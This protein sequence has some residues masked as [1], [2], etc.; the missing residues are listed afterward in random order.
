MKKR[1]SLLFFLLTASVVFCQ[2]DLLNQARV[3]INEGKYSASQAILDELPKSD[4]NAETMYLNAKSSK[5]L[6]QNDAIFLYNKLNI[7]FPYH[8]F[9]DEVN[10]D[11]ALI[12]YRQKQYADAIVFFLQVRELKNEDLFKLGYCYFL[13]DSLEQA[14]LYFFRIM[15]SDSK[16]AS[17]S[18]YYYSYILYKRGFYASALEGFK[19]LINDEKFGK[20]VPYYMSQIYF[21]Q[22][23]YSQLIKFA[24]PLLED[25]IDS[26]KSEIH[27][28]LAEAYYRTEDFTRAIYYLEQV[29]YQDTDKSSL[30]YFLLGHSYFKTKNYEYAISNLE[31]V[32]GSVDSIMQYSCYFLG[33]SYLQKKQYNYALQAFKKSS[34]F[35]Y[36]KKLQEDAYYNYAK[37]SYQLDL[38]F[39]NT[40]KIFRHYLEHFADPI[41]KK[42]LN[43][44]MVEVF[45][46]TSKYNEAYSALK[47]IY[48]PNINQQK[49]LQQIAFFLGVKEFN[50]QNFRKAISYFNVSNQYPISKYYIYLS[51]F[52]IAD[53]YY[54]LGEYS[55]SID[56]YDN[57][58]VSSDKNLMIYEDLKKYN[59]GYSY[60]QQADYM[61]SAKW[62]RSYEK[63]ASDSSR[64]HDTY[65]RIADS[66]FMMGDFVLSAK[67]YNKAVA[68][69]L[70]DIDYALYQEAVSLGLI[71][72]SKS[73]SILLKRLILDFPN[74][75]YYN[76]ALYA[77][78][79]YYRD[80]S[81]DDLALKYYNILINEGGDNDLVANAYISKGMINFNASKFDSAINNF[82]FIL[83]NY[84]KT[85][86]FKEA[87]SALQSVYTSMGNIEEY[88]SLI[89][90]LPEISITKAEQ[91]SLTYNTAFMKFSEMDYAIAKD[92]FDRYFERFDH[93]IFINEAAY[94]N[95]VSSLKIGDTVSAIINYKRLLDISSYSPYREN[96]LIFLARMAY[97]NLNYDQSN[98]YYSRL[99][100]CVSSNSIK[101]EA[102]IRL[103]LG[104][105]D[106]PIESVKY[107][108]Q[109][110]NLEKI[111]DWLL[112]K[113]YIIIAREEFTS[114]NYA[115]S[116]YTFEKVVSLSDY[117]EGAEAKYYLAYL[118]YLDDDLLLAEQL[119]FSLADDYTN[120]H[121]IAKAF[122]LLADIYVARDNIF[123]A[124][125]TLESVIDNHDGE[126]LVN[127][128]R[129]KW[130]FLI[131]SEQKTVVEEVVTESF[132][133]ILED[134]FEYEVQEIDVDYVVPIPDLDDIELDILDTNNKKN[135]QYEF[136]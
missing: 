121:F 84:Q 16:F 55:Q 136:E 82:L 41:H 73:K 66:Y 76:Y 30:L 9:Q 23:E 127:T 96:A 95:A 77:L 24:K 20:I 25:V 46:A 31:H 81:N 88:L 19:S 18:Q 61:N 38:P 48:L 125:A 43:A 56:V 59:L 131:E 113:A 28:L 120:D 21:Y 98:Q 22:K 5:E 92:A 54:H 7:D 36:N 45:Q 26:R 89:D 68:Y 10:N 83:N 32:S 110:V 100:D 39:E 8:N 107:A 105:I 115:K 132:I 51:N 134:D 74:S 87:L 12:Y 13:I 116:R 90:S 11:L 97:N 124:K 94:Y 27:R 128:A 63:V 122:I 111:D 6:F 103:M 62:F 50:Q 17:T 119:V 72:K 118:T 117:D 3:L 106:S 60:F 85:K 108:K 34:S 102:I 130:E 79:N 104:Y 29:M 15:N 2:N 71:R 47:E 64:I 80:V 40:L 86:Y 65:L 67:Y 101:R 69:N 35:D 33:A 42:E 37:L 78:A 109:V 126:A 93:G 75:S 44:L 91:D 133:E 49:D 57:L 53:S 14:Q 52:W 1:I 114:G 123:Q 58:N 135:L 112:S 4:V 129:K 70:F 99:L